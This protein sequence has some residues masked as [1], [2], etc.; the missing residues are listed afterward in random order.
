MR[1]SGV[2]GYRTTGTCPLGHVTELVITLPDYGDA[3]DLYQCAGCG[4]LFGVS[5]DAE[6]YIGPAWD[7]KRIN[8]ACP[9]CGTNLQDAWLYPDHFRCLTC[10]EIGTEFQRPATYPSDDQRV[11]IDVWDPYT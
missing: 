8:E 1:R 11:V 4:E 2:S 3:K 10:D 9:N 7:Q 5:P 6:A